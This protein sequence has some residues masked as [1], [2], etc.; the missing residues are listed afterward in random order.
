MASEA[1]RSRGGLRGLTPGEPQTASRQRLPSPT[2]RPACT[3]RAR[4]SGWGAHERGPWAGGEDRYRRLTLLALLALLTLIVLPAFAAPA[5]DPDTIPY[6]RLTWDDFPVNDRAPAGLDAWT[7]ALILFHYRARY[8]SRRGRYVAVVAD[9]DFA[10]VFDR[11]HS[12]RRARL[13]MDP[14]QLLAHE[15]GHF[16]LNEL[17][18]RRVRQTP[19]SALPTG[20]GATS[21]E[22]VDDLDR[23]F[24]DW[25]DDH[26]AELQKQHERYD[27]ETD[28][29]RRRKPQQEWTAMLEAA[30]APPPAESD[31]G[32]RRRD[33]AAR[34]PSPQP[35]RSQAI[36]RRRRAGATI[37]RLTTD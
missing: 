3:N 29:G 7:H 24:R 16:D 8:E 27:Q 14:D 6:R 30:L 37:N 23:A 25:Y 5:A 10:G 36:Y 12:W 15:Q 11:A 35:A 2:K 21:R 26:L 19:L 22:A 9:A 13:S 32:S 17:M 34:N 31:A 18:V 1:Q 20:T 28:S 33:A 4:L